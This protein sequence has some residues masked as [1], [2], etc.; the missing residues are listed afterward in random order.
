MHIHLF[1]SSWVYL[2]PILS[3]AHGA[4]NMAAI[5]LGETYNSE[6]ASEDLFYLVIEFLPSGLG[7]NSTSDMVNIIVIT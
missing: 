5:K 7:K 6:L 1:S 3:Q 4:Q 2:M